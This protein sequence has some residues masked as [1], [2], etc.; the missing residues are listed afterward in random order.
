MVNT[1]GIKAKEAKE[2]KEIEYTDDS[3]EVLVKI[4]GVIGVI[5]TILTIVDIIM[6]EVTNLSYRKNYYLGVLLLSGVTVLGILI[7][8][9]K[10]LVVY[11]RGFLIFALLIC[12]CLLWVNYT[13]YERGNLLTSIVSA[14]KT[15]G[16]IIIIGFFLLLAFLAL[17]FLMM[18]VGSSMPVR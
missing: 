18:I 1:T 15:V 6:Y 9:Y 12:L 7:I 10:N 3:A 13:I 11:N 5:T 4:I 17:V 16:G 8:L 14:F 2:A